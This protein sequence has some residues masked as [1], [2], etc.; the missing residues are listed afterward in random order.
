V[1][2]PSG[3]PVADALFWGNG[4]GGMDGGVSG[5][6]YLS[7]RSG[8]DGRFLVRILPGSYSTL[9]LTPGTE[10]GG[11]A[12]TSVPPQTWT[13]DTSAT[14]VL[15]KGVTLAGQVQ[16]ADGE[17]PTGGS[18]HFYPSGSSLSVNVPIADGGTYSALVAPGTYSVSMDYY[19]AGFWGSNLPVA[20][21]YDTGDGGTLDVRVPDIALS[22]RV[23]DSSGT[24]VGGVSIS[25]SGW[26]NYDGGVLGQGYLSATSDADGRFAARILP[27]TYTLQ[28]SPGDGGYVFTTLPSRTFTADTTADLVVQRG[29]PASGRILLANGEA[30]QSGSVRFNAGD[31]TSLAATVADGGTWSTLVAP[32]TYSI[33]LDYSTTG[34][35]GSSLL[36]ASQVAI[37]G[38]Y[39]QSFTVP[40]VA[41]DGRVIDSSGA[42]VPGVTLSGSGWPNYDGGVL[43]QG[44]LSA[45]SGPDGRFTARVLPESYSSLQ[46]SPGGAADAGYVTTPVPSQ[47]ISADTS[48]DFVIAGS[49]H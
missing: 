42:P 5:Q 15:Q 44:Y 36:L 40:D 2:D 29:V 49:H 47:T 25:G 34:F 6:G 10:D 35:W 46:L 43:G 13:A 9:A 45:T 17:V 19:T 12:T 21:A 16:L 26:P 3:A 22:G 18:M 39:S 23:I 11:F 48:E 7:A 41:L 30:P 4:Y 38:G 14:F 20:N 24:P 28:L 27:E 1:V 32:G 8:A 37:D 33:S 31:G